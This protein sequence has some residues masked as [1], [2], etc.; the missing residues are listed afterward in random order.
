MSHGST[1][2]ASAGVIWGHGL[3]RDGVASLC[4]EA[5]SAASTAHCLPKDHLFSQLRLRACCSQEHS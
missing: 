4:P 5:Y 2:Q 3:E 1:E